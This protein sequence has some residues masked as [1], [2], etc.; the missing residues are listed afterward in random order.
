MDIR[1]LTQSPRQSRWKNLHRLN[2]GVQ[3]P[4]QELHHEEVF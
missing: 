3:I 2:F 4:Q 1:V